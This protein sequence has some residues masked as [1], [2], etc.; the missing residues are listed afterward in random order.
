[1][2]VLRVFPLRTDAFLEEMIVGL[3]GQFGGWSD[4]ILGTTEIMSV[5]LIQ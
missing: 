4:I 5:R 1:M 2:F 3:Q